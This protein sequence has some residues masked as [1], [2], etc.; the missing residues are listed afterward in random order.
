MPASNLEWALPEVIAGCP[1]TYAVSDQAIT[2]TACA[3]GWDAQI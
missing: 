2:P 3:R 1:V